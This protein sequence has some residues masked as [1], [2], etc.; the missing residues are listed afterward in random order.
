MV[1]KPNLAKHQPSCNLAHDL[2]NKLSIIVGNCD[3]IEGKAEDSP[4]CRHRLQIIRRVAME[5]AKVLQ[6]HQ[7]DLEALTRDLPRKGVT[8]DPKVLPAKHA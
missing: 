6:H 3:L 5:M 4:V 2:V 1:D 8:M 7:C